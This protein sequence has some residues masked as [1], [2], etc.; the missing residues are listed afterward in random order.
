[1]CNAL[2][3]KNASKRVICSVIISLNG[4]MEAFSR[5]GK[6]FIYTCAYIW[7][8]THPR[9]NT[10][11]HTCT[12]AS[13]FVKQLRESDSG[14]REKG[15]RGE[16]MKASC[17]V[18]PHCTMSLWGRQKKTL[19]IYYAGCHSN[20]STLLQKLADLRKQIYSIHFEVIWQSMWIWYDVW[21]SEKCNEW[22]T[23]VTLQQNKPFKS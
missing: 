20:I 1:M 11:I 10:C 3:M 19:I 6:R 9:K 14:E 7:T 12:C 13:R 4:F 5:L 17:W 21:P 18:S 22:W 15:R 8:S 23:T 2:G 16:Q